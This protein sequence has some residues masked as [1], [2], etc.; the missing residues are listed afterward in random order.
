MYYLLVKGD[1]LWCFFI[2]SEK[3]NT[4]G[5]FWLAKKLVMML[6]IFEIMF[7][8]KFIKKM[9]ININEIIVR[10]LGFNLVFIFYVLLKLIFS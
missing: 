1:N 4:D 10:V 9:F 7:F 8:F 6:C 5:Y 3:R 2:Q